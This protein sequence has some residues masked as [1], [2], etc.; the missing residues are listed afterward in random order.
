MENI[1][2]VKIMKIGAAYSWLSTYEPERAIVQITQRI[3]SE[4]QGRTFL[5]YQWHKHN[6]ITHLNSGAKSYPLEFKDIED[7]DNMSKL[8]AAIAKL[9]SDIENCQIIIFFHLTSYQDLN[10]FF[11]PNL[12]SALLCYESLLSQFGNFVFVYWDKH[13]PKLLEK[14]VLV[15]EFKLPTQDELY[16]LIQEQ[17]TNMEAQLGIII[18]NGNDKLN[19]EKLRGMTKTEAE[20]TIRLAYNHAERRYETPI[21]INIKSQ[22]LEK[23]AGLKIREVKKTFIAGFDGI[24]DVALKLMNRSLES[25]Q[26]SPNR[27]VICAGISGTGKSLFAEVLAGETGLPLVNVNL[28]NTHGRYVGDS[29]KGIERLIACIEAFGNGIFLIDELDKQAAG[30]GG[31]GDSD[32]G[33]NKR[34]WGRFLTWLNDRTTDSFLICTMNNVSNLMAA[35]P[36]L[37]RAGRFDAFV[38]KDIPTIEER[39]QVWEHY[40]KQFDITESKPKPDDTGWTPAEIE[41]CCRYAYIL[42]TTIKEAGYL[43][44]PIIETAKETVQVMRAFAKNRCL[45]ARTGKRFVDNNLECQFE[46]GRKFS[47]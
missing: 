27:G 8:I 33:V 15:T 46:N 20:N 34:V 12:V 41:Q 7:G 29:E 37:F 24:K 22:I 11:S 43:I 6:G 39:E 14:N 16:A 36:E 40:L 5:I 18:V 13:P 31:S 21:I 42:N 10:F 35:M 9:Q 19:A 45:D 2:I 17:R 30:L 23:E 26:K 28:G 47:I 32:G 1:D 4:W 3:E 38:Y 44:T 25:K